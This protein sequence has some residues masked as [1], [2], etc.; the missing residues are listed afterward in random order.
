M[1]TPNPSTD[2]KIRFYDLENKFQELESKFLS[3]SQE[4]KIKNEIIVL[5]IGGLINFLRLKLDF[6][7]T[8]ND[9]FLTSFDGLITFL[10]RLIENVVSIITEVCPLSK[11]VLSGIDDR[12]IYNIKLDSI[13]YKP[14]KTKYPEAAS[15]PVIPVLV[16]DLDENGNYKIINTYDATNGV[17][18]SDIDMELLRPDIFNSEL[19]KNE[20]E[21]PDIPEMIKSIIQVIM[22]RQVTITEFSVT[23]KSS[24]TVYISSNPSQPQPPSTYAYGAYKNLKTAITDKNIKLTL[25]IHNPT[26][27]FKI[28][29]LINVPQTYSN[30]YAHKDPNYEKI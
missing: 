22:K 13:V 21:R 7:D 25:K 14:D 6:L 11:Y 2:I 26:Q 20:D 5:S 27:A 19:G 9:T 1:T 18:S 24:N 3:S 30:C 10:L 29:H 23:G 4:D 17:L 16:P 15:C 12:D 8:A 28:T